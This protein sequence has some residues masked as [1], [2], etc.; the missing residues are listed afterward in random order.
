MA[1]QILQCGAWNGKKVTVF[2]NGLYDRSTSQY[3]FII[4]VTNDLSSG[5]VAIE[6]MQPLEM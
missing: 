4:G 6:C 3:V 1:Q 5:G 2:Y